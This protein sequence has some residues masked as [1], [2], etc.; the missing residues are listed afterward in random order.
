MILMTFLFLRLL[1]IRRA[2]QTALRY[3]MRNTAVA[4]VTH[5]ENINRDTTLPLVHSVVRYEFL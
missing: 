1:D 2:V 3:K 5:E 4:A